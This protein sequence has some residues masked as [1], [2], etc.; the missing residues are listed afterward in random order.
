MH[1]PVRIGKEQAG[2]LVGGHAA[3]KAQREH[4]R[5]EHLSGA[6]ANLGQQRLLGLFVRME[7]L[8][9][10]QV[11]R[12]AQEEVVATPG[13]NVF[14]Q[15]LLE[16]LANPGGRMH[17]VGDG[18]D[19][20]LREHGPRNLTVLHGHA[21]GVAAETEREQRH[22]QHA[23]ANTAQ[24]FQARGA[25]AA[26]DAPGLLHAEAVVPR[27]HRGMGGKDAL[28]TNLGNI[29]LGGSRLRSAAQFALQQRQREQRGMAFVHVVDVDGMAKSAGHADAAH[30]ENDFL[31][32]PI[33]RV[34]SVEVVGQGAVPGGVALDVGV[35]Q[36]DGHHVAIAANQ[37][38]APGTHR[39]NAAL[40]GDGDACSLFRAEFGRVPGLVF[41]PLVAG[42]GKVL[43][44]V[45]LAMH[46]RERHQR[47]AQIGSRAQSVTGQ[48]AQ[49]ARVGGHRRVD[50]DFHGEVCDEPG[51]RK[52]LVGKGGIGIRLHQSLV[53][54][55]KPVGWY[56][57]SALTAPGQMNRHH[58]AAK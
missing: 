55:L 2:A 43:L 54:M 45:A 21:I 25:I 57:T 3:G 56:E 10:G 1:Q 35:E 38:I 50:G 26:E 17:S 44:E 36:V 23:V 18:V 31:L 5:V 15:Q 33:I 6:R 4:A 11:D 58:A 48:Y 30:A 16:G 8:V 52:R 51:G 29:G 12:V 41:F 47:H 20:K 9:L 34:A 32:Q 22:V 7:N 14:V 42:A 37:L 24:A 28:R 27:G 46:Q 40:N 53:M 39:D 19:G 13:G 49:A